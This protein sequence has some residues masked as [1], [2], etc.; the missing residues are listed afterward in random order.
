MITNEEY[1]TKHA[2]FSE[3]CWTPYK[4]RPLNVPFYTDVEA[5]LI[6][7]INIFF[8]CPYCFTD[9]KKNGMPTKRA[10]HYTHIHGSGN[11]FHNRSE[12]RVAHCRFDGKKL[13]RIHIT[14]NTIR[15]FN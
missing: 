1:L 2:V 11:Q 12:D 13:F 9:Y 7:P 6:T 14:D 5:K 10:K 3:E 15:K 8:E 4:P